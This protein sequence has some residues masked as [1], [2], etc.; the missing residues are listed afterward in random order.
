MYT[1][2]EKQYLSV[3][4]G[5]RLP[6]CLHVYCMHSHGSDVLMSMCILCRLS[7]SSVLMS[8]CDIH[9]IG[10]DTL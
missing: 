6:V 10:R 3:F 9:Y 8:V 7:L 5:V 1:R 2:M 4:L